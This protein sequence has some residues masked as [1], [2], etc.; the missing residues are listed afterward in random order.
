M[1]IHASRLGSP[2][3]HVYLGDNHER[4]E[5]R[6]WLVIAITAAMMVVEITAGSIFGSMALIAD[7]WHMS[8][9]AGAMLI[10]ALAY[11]YARRNARNERFTFGTGKMG[12]LAGFASAVILA[13]IALLIGWESGFHYY[14]LMFI[15]AIY[16]GNRFMVYAL[17]PETQISVHVAWGFRKQNTAVMIG[18][19]ILDKRSEANIGEICL[20][21]GGGGH[22][23]AGTCQ[24]DNDKV[25]ELLPGIIEALNADC[26]PL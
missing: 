15:P 20:S 10:A 19:S 4:N 7:G 24:L 17:Y 2:H 12:D 26:T 3:E 13:L 1:N 11:R 5:R 8:T 14:L 25:D 22:R 23:N 21:H 18:K 6:T 9:H 16:A